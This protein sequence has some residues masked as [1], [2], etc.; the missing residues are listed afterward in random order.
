M[1]GD[2]IVKLAQKAK[3]IIA[4]GQDVM[5]M[6]DIRKCWTKDGSKENAKWIWDII[7]SFFNFDERWNMI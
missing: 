1:V 5:Y 3:L 7:F 2:K 4:E 6:I